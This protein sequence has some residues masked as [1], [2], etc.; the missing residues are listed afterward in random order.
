MSGKQTEFLTILKILGCV[1]K[2]DGHLHPKEKIPLTQALD[3]LQLPD[4]ISL[5]SLLAESTPFEELLKQLESSLAIDIAY[6]SAYT[7]AYV[8][9]HCSPEEQELLDKIEHAFPDRILWNGKKLFSRALQDAQKISPFLPVKPITHPRKRKAK[10]Q[11]FIE[12]WSQVNAICSSFSTS[13]AAIA[14]EAIVYWNQLN[15]IQ[16]IGI[17]GG[18]NPKQEIPAL[19]ETVFSSLGITGSRLAIDA[20]TQLLPDRQVGTEASLGYQTTWAIGRVADAYFS[21]GC[22][23]DEVAL[24]S[25]FEV[26]QA[27]G[28]AAYQ[29]HQEKIAT[30][31]AAIEPQMRALVKELK[32]GQIAEE[33]YLVEIQY[34]F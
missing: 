1:A 21:Q 16:D 10:V 18:Y 20:L 12:F 23:M 14:T 11:T 9:G 28:K 13:Q 22:Q 2:A 4:R 31:Q 15:L 19:Q 17:I 7:L 3:C 32:A 26:A 33:E 6:Q 34:L 27:E 29:T 8:D 5:N 25:A 30:K 24:K